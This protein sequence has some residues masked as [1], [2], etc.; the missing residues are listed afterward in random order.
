[1]V[2]RFINGCCTLL[3]FGEE[4][5]SPSRGVFQQ[6][7]PQVASGKW[8]VTRPERRLMFMLMDVDVDMGWGGSRDVPGGPQPRLNS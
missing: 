5:P 7:T 1:M 4:D 6:D 3:N 8:Q 2:A